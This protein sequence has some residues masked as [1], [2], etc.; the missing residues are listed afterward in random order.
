MLRKK[1]QP[2]PFFGMPGA[3]MNPVTG[4]RA[5]LGRDTT[6]TRVAMFQVI[7]ADTHDNYVV[8]RGYDFEN[9]VFLNTVSVAK[10]YGLRGTF[11][12]EVG[13]VLA[14]AKPRMVLGETPG[15]ASVTTGQPADLNETVAI[16]YD[17]NAKPVAWLDLGVGVSTGFRLGKLDAEWTTGSATVSV[18]TWNGSAW[19]DSG[20]NLTVYQYPWVASWTIAI[21]TWVK[22]DYHG[23]AKAWYAT[24][25]VSQAVFTDW[26]YNASSGDIEEK[27]RTIVGPF[28]GAESGWTKTDD[29]EECA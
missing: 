14:A 22:L 10:P 5:P 7:A 1:R 3:P 24:P 21:S 18:W 28:T 12:Y 19:A 13:H 6:A 11:P 27:T 23:Q 9:R 8:C 2:A 15:V 26:Q 17:A 25:M 29:T 4:K 20:E 16:L